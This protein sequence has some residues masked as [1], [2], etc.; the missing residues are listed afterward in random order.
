MK[1]MLTI[2]LPVLLS[3][4]VLHAQT[5][6][7]LAWTFTTGGGIYAS[8]ALAGDGTIYV[9]SNDNKL[10]AVKPDGTKKWE[11]VT[12]GGVSTPSLGPDGTIYASSGDKK[13]YAVTAA[14]AKKWAFETQNGVTDVA[15][16]ADGTI[17]AGS[18][19]KKL[20]AI[21]ADGTR[22]WTFEA[23]E[24]VRQPVIGLDG[25]IYVRSGYY[26]LNAL[27]PDGKLKWQYFQTMYDI[28]ALSIGY[29]G[30]IYLNCSTN[31]L[32][33]NP[34]GT[35]KWSRYTGNCY[36]QPI[37]GPDSTIYV[38]S[39]GNNYLYAL[40][41]NGDTRWTFY[42]G[43]DVSS[44]PVL[45][46]DGAI[47][48]GSD[49]GKIYSLTTN[50]VKLWEYPTGGDVN[51][52]PTLSSQGVL[53][54]GCTDGKLYALNISSKGVAPG[55]W[56]KYGKNMQNSHNGLNGTYP[57]ARIKRVQ[58]NIPLGQAFT[59]DAG[60]S[61]DGDG[62]TLAYQ[63][64]VVYASSG[65]EQ[66][67]IYS[68]TSAVTQAMI[69]VPGRYKI[70]LK[71]WDAQNQA[72]YDVV[73][74]ES[75]LAWTFTTGGSISSSPAL[76]SDGTIYVG[77]TDNKLYAVNGDG[78]KKWEFSTGGDVFTPS[79][80]SDGTIY[81]GSGDKKLYAVNAG[82]IKKWAFETQ[83]SVMDI[84]VGADGTIY[85]GS[86]DKKLYAIHA[87]GT[88]KWTYEASESLQQ[89]V[90]GVDGTIYV[91]SGYYT[92]N[93]LLPDGTLKWQYTLTSN[94][95]LSAASIGLDG[96]IYLNCTQYTKAINPDGTEKWSKYTS[97]CYTQ[98]VIG[99]DST[100]YVGSD[101]NNY[102]YALKPN[103][104]TRWTYNAGDDINS[105][106]ALGADG[107]I[108][109]GSDNDGI[110][111]V[112]VDGKKLWEYRT[113]DDVAS[114]PTLS[115]Q[116]MLYVGCAD[117]KLYALNI[118]S[119]GL[120]AGPWPKYGKNLQNSQ[121]GLNGA[122]PVARIKRGQFNIR[123]GQAFTL[124]A[125]MSVDGD[126]GALFIEWSVLNAS[127]GDEQVSIVSPN[128]AITQA[129]I[130]V[131]GRY[132]I[133]LKV[134]DVQKQASYDVI[135]LE[136][137]LAWTFTTGGGIYS[138]PALG[139]DGTIY[140]G[141]SDNKLYALNSDGTKKWEFLTGGDVLTP[142][143]GADGTIYV[144][145]D[146]KKLYAIST[147]GTKKWAFDAQASVTDVAIGSDG[148]IY[149][150]SNDKKLYAIN[151]DG[152]R[153]WTYEASESLGPPV[154]D[155]DGTIYVR[156]GY[157]TL[158]ALFPQGTLKW[159]YTQANYN[160]YASPA[161]GMDGTIYLNCY[162]YT[163]A[164][165]PNGAEKWRRFTGNCYTQPIVGPD[166]TIYAGSAGDNRL[167]A[168]KPNGEQKWY[169][170][171]GEDV[172][173]SPLLGEDGTIYF[174]SDNDK[175]FAVSSKGERVWE[176]QTAG[177]V[178]GSP[179]L[180]PQ[181]VLYVG[182]TD[183]KLYALNTLSM[184]LSNAPWPKYRQNLQN[185]GQLNS[186]IVAD[187]FQFAFAS[188]DYQK[189]LRIINITPAAVVLK[190][191]QCTNPAYTL[192][193]ALP[194]TIASGKTEDL[195]LTIRVDTTAIYRSTISIGY[196]TLGSPKTL[197]H[198]VSEGL[199]REDGSEKS[200][201]AH[202][203]FS[204]YEKSLAKDPNSIATQNN[205]G[206]LY[207]LLGDL[208]Q[209]EYNIDR[210]YT[211]SMG[212]SF[213]YSGVSVN[214]GVLKSD[215][216]QSEEAKPYYLFAVNNNS[217][218]AE[219]KAYYNLAWEAF[220]QDSLGVAAGYVQ[221]TLVG[222]SANKFLLAK[223]YVLRGAIRARLRQ[224]DEAHADFNQAVALDPGGPI[225]AMANE[226]IQT[227]KTGVSVN[228]DVLPKAFALLPNYPNP[229]NP[230]TFIRFALPKASRVCIEIYNIQGQLVQTLLD[231]DMAPGW[232]QIVWNG[233]N[234]SGSQIG[235]GVYL[236]HFKAG[237][238][239]QVRKMSLVR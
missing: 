129:M 37:I 27:F 179:T 126:G 103:G 26:T 237:E 80:G 117:G 33:L 16:G 70:S 22:K 74:L 224:F 17:Y 8:P 69:K 118:A 105:A 162:Q 2:F 135:E 93:A 88:R 228:P 238:F 5:P 32:A 176:Y 137:G 202:Q 106:P 81:V 12:G 190:S 18:I 49:A 214:M 4:F 6:G 170:A 123:L 99:P 25:T 62:G 207:R 134:W 67:N 78:T 121:N 219:K 138:S 185:T 230:E 172:D 43:G 19:D 86:A 1:I 199:F 73:E 21:N 194:K 149:M 181:G 58:N 46:A 31:T 44:S 145:S 210:A 133:K 236:L 158:I 65:A 140:V 151:A 229:F 60:M 157:Y 38:G 166:S 155:V 92:L 191:V 120:A 197:T 54:V 217:N 159:Q 72:S 89:P 91:R 188:A 174:G 96:T 124:D 10:Y 215:R 90:I 187:Q 28:T 198:I 41:P 196:E 209:A 144:G 94:S 42:A 235:S 131:P 220:Q 55:P 51:S 213:G 53:Y 165:N 132:K 139:S 239:Q 171:A 128:S 231:Q 218:V 56:P 234:E 168:L 107:T 101:G 104:E 211:R 11:F 110:S 3:F 116:G 111:A 225:G 232:Q 108:Y 223:A 200:L 24:H 45:G 143:L 71:V 52:S 84:A 48:F 76:A 150:G 39:D 14:G 201:I 97:N 182:S 169:F 161:I 34:D 142:S 23:S 66:V 183:G 75:G 87:D 83:G 13:L 147:S 208:D 146:D 29:E 68:P 153:K 226:N 164:L 114:S 152:T 178:N 59:L 50:G 204:L 15:I 122:Y 141:S 154:V 148:T 47:Y 189:W 186:V 82:G 195:Q 206:V 173:S 63:W 175:I 222:S 212:S 227:L 160:I 113:A 102:L 177:D 203:A 112:T 109:F 136:A 95:I 30:T 40:K 193:T 36:T 192:S 205:V 61:V 180:S 233:L 216:K 79:L 221:Q 85:A 184:G 35:E 115:S 7:T 98:P 77:S 167:Y 119:K 130:K 20:Y 125:S 57:V 64:S 127:S 163:F 156:S 9:G 100:I